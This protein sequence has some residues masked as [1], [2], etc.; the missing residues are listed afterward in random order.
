MITTGLTTPL[1]Q[2]E[3]SEEEK[4]AIAKSWAEYDKPPAEKDYL[5]KDRPDY[6]KE[7]PPQ[8]EE[9]AEEEEG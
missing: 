4:K 3:R 1:I 7:P 6:T 5:G 9:E 2:E 8:E